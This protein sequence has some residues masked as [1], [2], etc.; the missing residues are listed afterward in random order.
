MHLRYSSQN[1]IQI[2][3]KP[4]A[5]FACHPDDFSKY[6]DVI[7]NDILKHND[8]VVYYYEPYAAINEDTKT[9]DF[10]SIKVFV[11]AV[12]KK[13]LT[14]PN[15]AFDYDLKYAIKNHKHIIPIV[16]EPD[17][18]A[19]ALEKFGSIQFVDKTKFNQNEYDDKITYHTKRFTHE[20]NLTRKIESILEGNVFLS[21][22]K[23]DRSAARTV[24][25]TL[26]RP[27][28]N[29][30][31]GIWYDEFLIP[32]EDFNEN[33]A[34]GIK[35]CDIFVMVITPNIIEDNNY[36]LNSEYPLA[37]KLNKFIIPIEAK[38]TDMKLLRQKFPDLPP[39][40][41]VRDF[42]KID[43]LVKTA[44]KSRPVVKHNLDDFYHMG[45]AYL[46]GITVEMDIKRG[47]ELIKFAAKKNRINAL[48]KLVEMYRFGFDV[49]QNFD[50]AIKWQTLLVQNQEKI[51]NRKNYPNT[52][53][54]YCNGLYT[55]AHMLNE[56]KK[57]AEAE[58]IVR[59]GIAFAQNYKD[60]DDLRVKYK[61]YT[62][63]VGIVDDAGKYAEALKI[64]NSFIG[65]LEANERRSAGFNSQL[66]ATYNTMMRIYESHND[67]EG[68][69]T[70]ARKNREVIS[71]SKQGVYS[72]VNTPHALTYLCEARTYLA[73]KNYVVAERLY[74]KA[75]S[76]FTGFKRHDNRLDIIN[77]HGVNYEIG[78]FYKD[79]NKPRIAIPYLKDAIM[80]I[81][82][83]NMD[84]KNKQTLLS[85]TINLADA[86]FLAGNYSLAEEAYR[87]S[88]NYYM[89]LC[90]LDPENY[91]A[92][93]G[94][95]HAYF[96]ER[97]QNLKNQVYVPPK[98][99][100]TISDIIF[101]VINSLNKI[102]GDIIKEIFK[103]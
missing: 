84:V 14:T 66:C 28:I 53:K 7:A 54:F 38:K 52:R 102:I 21:Y 40:V 29:R 32:G 4:K 2:T 39:C 26:H 37:K 88:E 101:S 103:L 65:E 72:N 93:K 59:K 15:E 86:Y 48:S 31:L 5:Y 55:L 18:D 46:E 50:E 17:L 60:K 77:M 47:L 70:M 83:T 71:R 33:I 76:L 79:W 85:Y 13:F 27:D 68:V 11:F 57:Y 3:K 63:L 87:D 34:A 51:T 78:C 92:E 6:K 20:E 95:W 10:S 19:L 49:E 45:L 41:G 42:E 25:K 9:F 82:Y 75:L 12:T 35:N 8:C 90:K 74:K 30:F 69:R 99:T 56:Q 94:R 58:A 100:Y 24:M 97:Y 1:N 43:E 67:A 91:K 62:L 61:L 89:E 80:Y 36:V 22:R 23:K 73:E 44:L 96:L 98:N 81:K 64:Y 16:V